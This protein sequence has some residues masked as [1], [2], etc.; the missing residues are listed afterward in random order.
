M[1]PN[2]GKEQ[3]GW[4]LGEGMCEWC[5]IRTARVNLKL[6]LEHIVNVEYVRKIRT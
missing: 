2:V 5:G 6:S 1:V 4:L 3:K